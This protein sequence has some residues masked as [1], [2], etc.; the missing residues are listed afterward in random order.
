MAFNDVHVVKPIGSGNLYYLSSC[1]HNFEWQ[2]FS[3][4][5]SN[6]Q[7]WGSCG[8][9]V[10]GSSLDI[11][12]ISLRN[13]YGSISVY[14]QFG[15]VLAKSRDRDRWRFLCTMGDWL[16]SREKREGRIHVKLDHCTLWFS[17]DL[18]YGT[19]LWCCRGVSGYRSWH[20][21]GKNLSRSFEHLEENKLYCHRSLGSPACISAVLYIRLGVAG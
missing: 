11:L 13:T 20:E 17:R 16:L 18:W 6:H 2:K 9:S 3:G 21:R 10:N 12:L 8:G 7:K 14:F 5:I 1:A 19:S 4:S 15:I